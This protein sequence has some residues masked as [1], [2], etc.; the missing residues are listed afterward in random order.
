M[1]W[2]FVILVAGS[3]KERAGAPDAV[4]V[5]LAIFFAAVFFA[6]AFFV[7]NTFSYAPRVIPQQ[8]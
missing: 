6:G 4:V 5:L 3:F 8:R 1:S 7:A 2:V